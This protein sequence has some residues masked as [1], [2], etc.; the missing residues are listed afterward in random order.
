MPSSLQDTV[1]PVQ[2]R[3]R[4]SCARLIGAKA[5]EIAL[6]PNTSYGLSLAAQ[7]LPLKGALRFSPHIFNTPDELGEA[8]SMLDSLLSPR[9]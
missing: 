4:E 5:A 1:F 9:A 3:T 8:L 2:R 6:T 7:A